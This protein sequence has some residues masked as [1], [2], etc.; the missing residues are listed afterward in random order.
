MD[1]G[2]QKLWS[3]RA[4]KLIVLVDSESKSA[5]AAGKTSLPVIILKDIIYKVGME[6]LNLQCFI[7]AMLY[8]CQFDLSCDLSH[9]PLLLDG[10][11]LR[12]H[13]T[14][15]PYCIGKIVRK[16]NIL[17]SLYWHVPRKKHWL[18]NNYLYIIIWLM[19][20]TGVRLMTSIVNS[21]VQL[22]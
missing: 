18:I 10:G 11:F 5:D 12:W 20:I 21:M 7:Y 22:S 2:R 8:Y 14:Y 15:S 9:E 3:C 6:F 19:I 17:C 16:V 13:Q 4:N 1:T